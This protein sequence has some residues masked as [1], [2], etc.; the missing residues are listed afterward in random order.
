[1][2]HVYSKLRLNSNLL[3]GLHN[4]VLKSEKWQY[5]EIEQQFRD[6]VDTERRVSC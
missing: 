5:S 3:V 4:N 1:M 6:K 2:L